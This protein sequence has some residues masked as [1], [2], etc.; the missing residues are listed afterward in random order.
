MAQ[1]KKLLIAEGKLDKHGR[2]NENTPKEYLRS[3]PDV[4]APAQVSTSVLNCRTA[5]L[6]AYR[7]AGLCQIVLLLLGVTAAVWMI[8]SITGCLP[9]RQAGQSLKLRG[10]LPNSKAGQYPHQGFLTGAPACFNPEQG[11]YLRQVAYVSILRLTWSN[12]L[13]LGRVNLKH[14]CDVIEAHCYCLR[15]STG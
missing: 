7:Q 2:P 9:V 1:K 3:L 11:T 14:I 6:V 13:P 4:Q 15:F 10:Q 12:C 8:K 5:T